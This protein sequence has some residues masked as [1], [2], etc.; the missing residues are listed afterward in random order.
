MVAARTKLPAT[1]SAQEISSPTDSVVVRVADADDS[2]RAADDLIHG[3]DKMADDIPKRIARFIEPWSGL[4]E[5]RA[6][7][8]ITNRWHPRMND[9]DR[10]R[11]VAAWRKGVDRTLNLIETTNTE[12]VNS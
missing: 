12:A 6:N 11:G 2:G 4:D 1:A 5:L 8:S 9:E 7:Y 10:A 3:E